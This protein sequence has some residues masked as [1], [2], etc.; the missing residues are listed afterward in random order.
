MLTCLPFLTSFWLSLALLSAYPSSL[1]SALFLHFPGSEWCT[2]NISS[3]CSQRRSIV[4]SKYILVTLQITSLPHSPPSSL[5][6]STFISFSGNKLCSLLRR[7]GCLVLQI[8]PGGPRQTHTQTYVQ[9]R[10]VH[11]LSTS[12]RHSQCLPFVF[13]LDVPLSLIVVQK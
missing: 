7:H 3:H 2:I 1:W 11:L 9:P 12:W 8:S 4:Q 13:Y 10:E 6:W 5:V